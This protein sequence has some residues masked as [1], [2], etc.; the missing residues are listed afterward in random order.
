MAPDVGILEGDDILGLDEGAEGEEGEDEGEEGAEA[1]RAIVMV[2]RPF[3][4]MEL[5]SAREKVRPFLR[6]QK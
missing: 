1:T 2:F 4:Y 6:V 3:M 5:Y